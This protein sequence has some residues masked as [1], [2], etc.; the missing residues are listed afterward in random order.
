[1][2]S[3]MIIEDNLYN[4]SLFDVMSYNNREVE[5]YKEEFLA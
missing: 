5:W 1:M 4:I 2:L 3:V